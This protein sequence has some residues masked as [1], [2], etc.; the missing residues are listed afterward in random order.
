MNNFLNALSDFRFLK[1]KKYPDRAALK[2]IGDRYRLSAADRNCLFRGVVSKKTSSRRIS[3]L[4]K[5]EQLCSQPL[6]IDWFNVLITL[7]SYLKGH[8]VFIADDGVLRDSSGVHGSYRPGSVTPRATTEILKT[9]ICLLPESISIYIDSPISFSGETA[10]SLRKELERL[11]T[12]PSTVAVIPSAD[13]PLKSFRGVVA[14]SDSIIMDHNEGIFDLP[15]YTL[16][17]S[18]N[19]R[20]PDLNLLA[21]TILS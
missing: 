20:A 12:I 21:G 14:T 11:T 13:F 9:T 18:F 3:T 2:L 15:R 19:F 10:L 8:Q 1:N 6:G 4:L 7:E 17:R 16:L 5:P